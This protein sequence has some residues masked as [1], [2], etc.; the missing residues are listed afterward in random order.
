MKK[1]IIAAAILAAGATTASA[2]RYE[3]RQDRYPYA[4][5][6]HAMCQDKAERLHIIHRRAKADGRIS[7]RERRLV[8]ALE[9]DL[10]RSCGRFRWRG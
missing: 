5:Q 1:L 3:W 2:Q 6:Y 8:Q 4:R 10:D 7:W 9:R